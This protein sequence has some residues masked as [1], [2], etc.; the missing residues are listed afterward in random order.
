MKNQIEEATGKLLEGVYGVKELFKNMISIGANHKGEVEIH[1]STISKLEQQGCMYEL[2]K[3]DSK[4]FPYEKLVRM[5]DVTFFALYRAA[6]IEG[7][8]ETA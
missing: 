3:R 6:E 2:K 1:L 8:E 4:D 7:K 5:G